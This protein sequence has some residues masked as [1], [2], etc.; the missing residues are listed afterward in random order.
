MR[1]AVAIL[2]GK[3]TELIQDLEGKMTQA[4]SQLRFEEAANLRDRVAALEGLTETDLTKAHYGEARDAF[5]FYR[6]GSNVSLTV[7]S[8]RS[9]RVS[10][11]ASFSF[12]DNAQFDEEFLEQAIVQYY[13]RGATIPEEIL[14]PLATSNAELVREL[15]M[16]K[17]GAALVLVSE[18]GRQGALSRT[19]SGQCAACLQ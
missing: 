10:T 13:E 19:R 5:G 2:Q 15:L 1:E 8:F 14:L 9:G 12:A 18:G 17:R 6:E 16:Q 11:G 3:N 7:L 4:S